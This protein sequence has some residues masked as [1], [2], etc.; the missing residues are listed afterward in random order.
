MDEMGEIGESDPVT[1][2]VERWA[3]PDQVEA[4]EATLRG[5]IE[6]AHRFPG[7]RGASVFPPSDPTRSPY[8]V[9]FAFEHVADL[10]RWEQSDELRAWRTRLDEFTIDAPRVE[11]VS[12]LES[13]FGTPSEPLPLTPP[14]YKTLAVTWLAAYPLVT[15]L[16]ALLGGTLERLALPVRTALFSLTMLGLMIYV[17]MPRVTRLFDPWLNPKQQAGPT[18]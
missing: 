14:R 11:K 16:F 12:G 5:V 18:G 10:R 2:S 6:A 7:H 3:R 15:L 13:W 4:F 1:V 9:V 8:R 17:V